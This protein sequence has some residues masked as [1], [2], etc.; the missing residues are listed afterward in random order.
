MT[1]MNSDGLRIDASGTS[2]LAVQDRLADGGAEMRSGSVNS[3]ELRDVSV[4][5]GIMTRDVGTS[6]LE[7]LLQNV[8]DENRHP[9]LLAGPAVGNE[10]W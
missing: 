2:S 6:E 8:K 10:R 7:R 5:Q 3:T 4:P 9:D 1:K